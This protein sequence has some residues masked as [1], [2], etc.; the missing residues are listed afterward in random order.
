MFWIIGILPSSIPTNPSPAQRLANQTHPICSCLLTGRNL[1]WK[2]PPSGRFKAGWTNRIIYCKT[3]LNTFT[4]RCSGLLL[5][6]T[7]RF[8][9]TQSCVSSGSVLKMWC[10]EKQFASTST[11]NHGLIAMFEQPCQSSAFKTRNI[12]EQKQANYELWKTIKATKWQYNNKI[13]GQFN[14]NNARRMW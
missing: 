6:T 8:T 7:L 9:R 13:E 2:H 10:W 3:V 11:K 14:T 4:G 1:N 12:E 5:M